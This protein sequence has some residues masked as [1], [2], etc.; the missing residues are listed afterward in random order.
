MENFR[1]KWNLSMSGFSKSDGF[2]DEEQGFEE[3]GL[4]GFCCEFAVA[5]RRRRGIGDEVHE[6]QEIELKDERSPILHN[7]SLFFVLIK[8]GTFNGHIIPGTLFL[9][10]GIW[11]IWTATVRY[12]SNPKSFKVK[13]WNPIPG[14]NGKLRNLEL[15]VI[16][17]GCLLDICFELS[18]APN[19]INFEHSGMLIMFF[20]FG[21]TALLSQET[22]FLPLPVEA[23]CLISAIAF[24]AE[25]FLFYFHSTSHKGLE[26]YY[27][28]LL[29]ILIGLCIISTVA[30]A[31][32]PTSF[33]LDLS[34]GISITL[35]GVWFYQ[36]AFT[37]YGP[38]MPE[39]CSLKDDSIVCKSLNNQ[40]RGEMLA[41]FQLS[42]LMMMGLIQIN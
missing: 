28:L 36:T 35:H 38:M 11:H 7:K 6:L 18:Y 12:V 23:L 10:V 39:G 37:L 22:R 31:I 42:I 27:H 40:V 34:S 9:A 8:W 24:S 33:G 17:I 29:V 15:Y 1:G 14:I 21:F 20:I 5:P 13:A 30:G 16:T 41:N 3:L 26:G 32:V 19:L 4:I 25:S 2:R